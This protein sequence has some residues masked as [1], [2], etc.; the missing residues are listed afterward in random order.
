MDETAPL[1]VPKKTQIDLAKSS[2]RL[3]RPFSS[4]VTLPSQSHS[5]PSKPVPA[6][7]KSCET[8]NEKE[9]R[10]PSFDPGQLRGVFLHSTSKQSLSSL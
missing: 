8:G 10:I 1:T 4:K 6:L 3:S 9:V 5:P 2:D 7:R